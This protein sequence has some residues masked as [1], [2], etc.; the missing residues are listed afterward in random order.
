M[1][2][3]STVAW[4]LKQQTAD[5]AYTALSDFEVT[6][7][8]SFGTSVYEGSSIL[9][10]I[11]LIDES[12]PTYIGKMKYTVRYSGIS[13]AYI[14]VR[15]LEQWTDVSTNEVL[16]SGFLKYKVAEDGN[17]IAVISDA[18]AKTIPAAGP[19]TGTAGLAEMGKWVDNRPSDYAFY[20]NVPVQPKLLTLSDGKV[21]GDGTVELTLI[22]QHGSI[23]LIADVDPTLAQMGL[24]IEVEAVQPNRYREFWGISALPF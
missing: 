21:I 1:L 18:K 5:T 13:P 8:L 20:Y 23:D 3:Q 17:P 4:L 15:I 14:R 11:N 2:S 6:G 19:S 7:V 10:P 12:S 9:V 22:D 16:P 24:V